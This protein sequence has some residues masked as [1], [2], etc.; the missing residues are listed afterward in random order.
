M[1]NFF[2]RIGKFFINLMVICLILLVS[3]QIV[4]KND[5]AYNELKGLERMITG[6]FSSDNN[7]AVQV[8]ESRSIREHGTLV[9]DL[10]QDLSLPEVWLLRNGERVQSFADG[11]VRVEVYDGD[12]ISIDASDYRG[13]LWFEVTSVSHNIKN[14][15]Q[16]DQFRITNNILGLGVAEINSKL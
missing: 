14:W 9:V 10:M 1:N 13:V 8:T 2:N 7:Q 12:L 3:F 5:S 4:L 15:K 11:I 16:G 6:V